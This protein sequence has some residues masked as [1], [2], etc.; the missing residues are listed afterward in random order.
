MY[1]IN[2]TAIDTFDGQ[3]FQVKYPVY[4]DDELYN[5]I[6]QAPENMILQQWSDLHISTAQKPSASSIGTKKLP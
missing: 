4:V 6:T 3:T 1:T 5:T 2:F